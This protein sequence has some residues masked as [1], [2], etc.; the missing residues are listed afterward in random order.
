VKN[1]QLPE[2]MEVLGNWL[3]TY[4]ESK[5]FWTKVI[6]LLQERILL[7]LFFCKL[8]TTDHSRNSAFSFPPVQTKSAEITAEKL[9]RAP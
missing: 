8:L 1:F 9:K 7:L 4:K 6:R 2:S 5:A 3:H